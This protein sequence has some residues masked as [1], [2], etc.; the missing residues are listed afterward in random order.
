M[1]RT[2]RLT[3][4][5]LLLQERS[6][7]AGE[8]ARHFEVSRRT[9]LRD[10]QA[11]CEIG[12][13][14]VAR[15]GVGGGYSLPE[16]YWLAPPP[17]SDHEAFLLL[18]ALGALAQ[19]ADTPFAPER[20]SLVAKLRALLPVGQLAGVERLLDHIE[21]DAPRRAQRAPFLDALLDAAQARRWVRV[22]YQSAERRS[23]QH[24]LPRLVYAQGGFWYCRAYAH[25][26]GEE[27]SYRVD[28][29]QTLDPPAGDFA[30]PPAPEPTPYDHA[31]HPLVVAALTARGV[32]FV[33]SEPQLGQIILRE[34]H[35]GG[36]L[37]FRCP[38]SELDWFARYFASLG[39]EVGVEAPAELRERMRQIG[40]RLADRY[41]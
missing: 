20:A 38:P 2:D 19:Q 23:V 15:E 13:P 4:I 10:V 30:P 9:V 31:A 28:R 3:A 1:N 26:R 35:G 14:I 17:L 39:D 5:L 25:E 34:P 6:R 12:V 24:L 18:L 7:T 21:L 32:A 41:Q 27:R 33:E 40:Q 8:I 29:I 37:S 22:T 36:R 16:G 11:L